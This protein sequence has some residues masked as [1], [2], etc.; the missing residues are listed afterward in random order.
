MKALVYDG[1]GGTVYMHEAQPLGPYPT[2][3][4]DRQRELLAELAEERG[5]GR[6]EGRMAA[7]G[8]GR[9]SKFWDVLRGR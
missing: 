2:R 4:T 9:G 1:P 5:E 6:P 7:A 8:H 3:L